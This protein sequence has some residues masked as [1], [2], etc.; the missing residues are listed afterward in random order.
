MPRRK[1]KGAADE[2]A[3]AAL[4]QAPAPR[5]EKPRFR[6]VRYAD[7]SER[8]VRCERRSEGERNQAFADWVGAAPGLSSA[9]H[10]RRMDSLLAEVMEGMKLEEAALA[11]ELLAAAWQRAVGPFLATQAE[12]VSVSAG[13]A[14]VRAAHPAVLFELNRMKPQITRALNHALGEGSVKTVRVAHG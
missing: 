11:P 6:M 1:M 9:A 5:R 12:L 8:P 2:V 10:M 7:G 4:R 14:V 13:K 3:A